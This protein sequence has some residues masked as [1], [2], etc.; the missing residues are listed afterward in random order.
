[1]RVSASPAIGH[2]PRSGRCR[3]R[4]DPPIRSA[5]SRC[6]LLG[7]KQ[8][9]S[10][11]PIARAADEPVAAAFLGRR[12]GG[13]LSRGRGRAPTARSPRP[14]ELTSR[15]GA[16]DALGAVDQV[17]DPCGDLGPQRTRQVVPHAFDHDKLGVRDGLGG[18][19]RTAYV[20]QRIL[21]AV[22]HERRHFDRL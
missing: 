9:R 12:S 21:G 1:M 5:I 18:G 4:R 19:A 20:D 15:A 13:G 6:P 2:R 22:D 8:R 14:H 10:R 16:K 7:A 11:R 3:Y 17:G